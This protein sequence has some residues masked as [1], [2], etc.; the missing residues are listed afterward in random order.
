MYLKAPHLYCFARVSSLVFV[1]EDV[2]PAVLVVAGISLQRIL[3]VLVQR[4]DYIPFRCR[5]ITLNLRVWVTPSHDSR[6]SAA[7][8]RLR[9][10]FC[11][12]AG[13]RPIPRST[14]VRP[15]YRVSNMPTKTA[16]NGKS[17]VPRS[18][19][20]TGL[21]YILTASKYTRR[22]LSPLP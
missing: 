16:R 5:A 12:L 6:H 1:F 17:P 11:G 2:I 15:A 19:R 13:Y 21:S 4:N 14:K 10:T 18:I 7:S 3:V 8:A 22:S 9:V 20:S